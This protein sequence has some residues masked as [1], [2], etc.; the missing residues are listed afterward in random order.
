LGAAL[1][2]FPLYTAGLSTLTVYNVLF[3][4]GMF[5]S[6]LAAWALARELTG[7]AA[8]S[9]LAGVV[10]ALL[11]WRIS[12]LPHVQFQWGA[13]LPLLLLFLL[14]YLEAGRR[15][16]L[17]LF[18]LCLAW[19]A[20]A[21]VH[22][23]VF[24]GLLIAA[25]FLWR[26]L[27]QEGGVSRRRI[28]WA[29]LAAAGVGAIL[30]P[31]FYP[32]ALVSKLYGFQRSAHEAEWFS[33]RVV[34]FL[35]AG[36]RNKLYGAVTQRWSHAEGDFF[37]GIV[38]VVL[39]VLSLRRSRRTV[40]V[41]ASDR[42]RATRPGLIRVLDA[43]TVVLLLLWGAA[44]MRPGLSLGPMHLAD[45]SRVLVFATAAAFLRLSIAFPARSRWRNLADFLRRGPL[46]P[47]ASLL[48][49]LAA[50]GAVVALGLHTPYYRFLFVSFGAVFRS[51]RAPARGIVLFDLALAALAAWGLSLAAGARPG[52]RRRAAILGALVLTGIEYRAFP[53][54]LHDVPAD[55]GSVYRWL[56]RPE[57]PAGIMEWPLGIEHD[58]EYEFRSTAHWKPI[59]N[60]SS[61]FF[62]SEYLRLAEPLSK[63]PIPDSVW[64]RAAAVKATLL[65]FHPHDAPPGTLMANA[66]AV[67]RGLRDGRIELLIDL[68]HGA[69]RDFVFR[70]ASAPAF[71][72]GVTP[73][74]RRRAA[75]AFH[76]LT[77][78]PGFDSSPPR[79]TL[80]F[81][82]EGY[83]VA[84]GAIAHGWAVDDS[85]IV[86]V[87]VETELGPS[88]DAAAGDARADVERYFPGNPDG[89]RLGFHFAIP[90]LPP[91]DHTL[92][93]TAV[94]RDGGEGA[95][96][97]VI[98]V[99]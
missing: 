73:D 7:D 67:K 48:L 74:E 31:F 49:A 10:Y 19:N 66:E 75:E 61:G 22:Y 38:P 91:G 58:F 56:A 47:R 16:D 96:R 90:S 12:Q 64:E 68:P 26:W 85:G 35:S 76:T 33:G 15:R 92:T 59:V 95:L 65:V 71:D 27:L 18:A 37:P 36:M 78:R 43:A 40:A 72:A 23:A 21:N 42:T 97:R 39:A 80:D 13:F 4:L 62:P 28:A 93:V 44:S 17:A 32:Y 99:R 51:I 3:L 55:G 77:I 30:V 45:P 79:L 63:F 89:A 70:L 14:R 34:E 86:R 94:A 52:F 41:P 20:L 1:F 60:G 24:S 6:S 98:R 82:L 84:P 2:G 11:P 5:S 83:V 88:S 54:D 29:A 87:R 25:V 57:V 50:T 9:L 53:L 8:A 46:D 69:D 81:P